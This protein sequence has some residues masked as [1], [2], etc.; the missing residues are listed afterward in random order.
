MSTTK[1]TP[2]TLPNRRSSRSTSARDLDR[3]QAQ[4]GCGGRRRSRSG[5]GG[6]LGG[7]QRSLPARPALR[8]ARPRSSRH[9]GFPVVG[10][11]SGGGQLARMMQPAA[12]GAGRA[13]AGARRGGGRRPPPRSSRDAPVGAA[14]DAAGGARLRPRCDVVTFDHEHVPDRRSCTPSW[15]RASRVRPGPE[16]LRAR[17]GQGRR[18]AR[19][20]AELGVPCPRWARSSPTPA[21]VDGLRRRG[22]RLAGRAQDAP[23]RLRRQGRAGSCRRRRGADWLDGAAAGRRADAARRGAGRLPPRAGRAR[24]PLARRGQAAA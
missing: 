21:D 2:P 24:R 19:R 4:R 14:S 23:R 10:D 20:L 11:Q 15:P 16:A 12:V 1:A 6:C 22:R 13:P 7:G 18:C 5:A 8:D 9:G 17:P 3:H